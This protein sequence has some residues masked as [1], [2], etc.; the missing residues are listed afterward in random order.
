[1]P[2]LEDVKYQ[3]KYKLLRQTMFLELVRDGKLP[4]Y[5]PREYDH[6]PSCIWST[7]MVVR[8]FTQSSVLS[9]RAEVRK[10]AEFFLDRFFKR[11]F[12]SM[13]F[14]SPRNWTKL[15]DPTFF[16]SGACALDLLTW[17][18]FGA[19]D[20][21]MHRPMKWLI[22]AR[23][24]DGLWHQS[25]RPDPRKAEWITEV[26]LCTIKRYARSLAGEP[27]GVLAERRGR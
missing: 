7:M 9:R 14:Q 12:H 2:Y 3:P 6:I 21:R 16:G 19:E 13:F 24:P 20:S 27:F 5:D 4:P 11:N 1:V 22:E 10:G 8:G 18:G 26:A 25:E 15:R 23:S 17:L